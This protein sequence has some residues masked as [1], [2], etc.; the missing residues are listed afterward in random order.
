MKFHAER[1]AAQFTEE[2]D[3]TAMNE[4]FNK[5][6]VWGSLGKEKQRPTMGDRTEDDPIRYNVEVIEG[7]IQDPPKARSKVSCIL[8]IIF[9]P[10]FMK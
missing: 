4:K 9:V 5:D 2:F 8:C 6:E 3:F 10:K 1:G 7:Y